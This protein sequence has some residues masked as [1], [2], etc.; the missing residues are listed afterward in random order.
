M[1]WKRTLP[2]L[3]AFLPLLAATFTLFPGKEGNAFVNQE[4]DAENIKAL[5][6]DEVADFWIYDDLPAAKAIALRSKKPLLLSFR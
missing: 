2:A 4:T 1:M 5:L 6:R 3:A